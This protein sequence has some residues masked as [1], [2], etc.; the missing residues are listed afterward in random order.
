MVKVLVV[1]L[2]DSLHLD[3]RLRVNLSLMCERNLNVCHQSY[4]NS[5]S[6]L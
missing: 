6:T 3:V 5:H 2:Q 4:P 1:K